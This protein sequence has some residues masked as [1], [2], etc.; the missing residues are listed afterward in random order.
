MTLSG[1]ISQIKENLFMGQNS[2]IIQ[3]FFNYHNYGVRVLE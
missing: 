1:Y 3:E 2:I